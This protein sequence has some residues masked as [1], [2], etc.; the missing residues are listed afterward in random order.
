M[1]DEKSKL[2]CTGL[3]IEGVRFHV[4]LNHSWCSPDWATLL[5]AVVCLARFKRWIMVLEWGLMSPIDGRGDS[6]ARDS[7]IRRDLLDLF[8]PEHFPVEMKNPDIY[9][10][11]SSSSCQ[12]HK[13]NPLFIRELLGL[14]GSSK[15]AVKF[16]V[17]DMVRSSDN[18]YSTDHII[19]HYHL[20]AEYVG[21]NNLTNSVQQTF[22]TVISEY[23]LKRI[24]RSRY[25]GK[26]KISLQD[27]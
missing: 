2:K 17:I 26:N 14:E 22:W 12:F 25:P 19:R 18:H 5:H 9:T 1:L 7:I 3:I 27:N 11:A 8:Q 10:S 21:E 20:T 13:T 16:R 15:I 4:L 6:C 24:I 23:T